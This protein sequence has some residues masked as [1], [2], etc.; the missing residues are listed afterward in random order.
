MKWQHHDITILDEQDAVDIH[1]VHALLQQSY[2]ANTRSKDILRQAIA[3]SLCFSVLKDGKQIG[4]ARA[5]TDY[6]TFSWIADVIID[7]QYRSRGAGKF[8]MEC[9]MTHPAISHTTQTLCTRD[10]H[11]LY[12]RYGFKCAEFMR[13]RPE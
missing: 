9:I 2:W 12:Q 1:V 4:F 5:V 13:K 7:P 10:A 8:L 3:N 11:G 6:A